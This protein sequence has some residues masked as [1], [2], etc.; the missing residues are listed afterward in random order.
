M[1]LAVRSSLV[2]RS[3]STPVT[4]ASRTQ[5]LSQLTA[6]QG[7]VQQRDMCRLGVHRGQ[8]EVETGHLASCTMVTSPPMVT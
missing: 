4:T 2:A 3:R 5:R 8:G 7:G 1:Y 6:A